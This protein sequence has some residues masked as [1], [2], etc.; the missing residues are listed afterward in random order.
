[1]TIKT[2]LRCL[3]GLLLLAGAA[4]CMSEV[5][6]PEYGPT[7]EGSRSS[8][9]IELGVSASDIGIRTRAAAGDDELS[10]AFASKVVQSL[11]V[12]V[13]DVQTDS[14]VGQT[15]GFNP[16][17][18][19]ATVDILYYDAHPTLRVYGV[20]NY[21][22]VKARRSI[23]EFSDLESLL[24][25][26]R[27]LT[28]FYTIAVDAA[29]ANEAAIQS[30]APLMMGVFKSTGDNNGE[31]DFHTVE[32]V[33]DGS[34]SVTYGATGTSIT[35]ND[36]SVGSMYDRIDYKKFDGTIRLRRLL[37]QVNV[38]VA[39]NNG[40]TVS[41]LRYRKVNMPNEVYLQERQTYTDANGMK[42]YG[43]WVSK[44]PNKADSL[45]TT[46]GPGNVGAV[47]GY[48]SD[49]EF[50][51][52]DGLSFTFH[53]YE[54]KHWGVGTVSG[55]NGREAV[56]PMT[57]F[58][59]GPV[60]VALCTDA[61]GAT[62]YNNY[63]SYFEISLDVKDDNAGKSGTV[64]YRIHEGRCNDVDGQEQNPNE[65]DFTCIRNTKY[66]YKVTVS[67]FDHIDVSVNHNH[68][69]N[70]SGVAK[71][72]LWTVVDAGTIKDGAPVSF[73]DT[74]LDYVVYS[75]NG[76]NDP[77]VFGS[78]ENSVLFN[79]PALSGIAWDGELSGAFTWNGGDL[80]VDG[81]DGQIALDE[82]ITFPEGK[83]NP[84]DYRYELYI[85]TAEKDYSD[86]G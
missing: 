65:W 49:A 79:L 57:D 47:P 1:M 67:G 66:T 58:A 34:F 28:D 33:D 8:M 17:S 60:F 61:E 40:V 2:A 25:E 83:Y 36:A 44:S 69:G 29:S 76:G 82:E 15:A 37:S 20:A 13:F 32:A 24:K 73:K 70:N 4:S 43:T 42:S 23:D 27:T 54:N 14:L 59:G 50:T 18:L 80:V 6:A 56:R 63:A 62:I 12:G 30:G 71:G 38:T 81:Q 9:R 48:D 21:D 11:W 26:V 86:A 5:L 10:E 52:A 64:V 35:L 46:N 77:K 68:A 85:L 55:L 75:A 72:E 84:K 78:D 19:T 31:K 53:Q 22:G 51:E 3:S 74:I 41:N 45:I 16:E 7:D 39:G